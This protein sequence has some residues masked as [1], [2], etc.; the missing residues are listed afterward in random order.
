MLLLIENNKMVSFCWGSFGIS[1]KAE[2]ESSK[3][4]FLVHERAV[5]WEPHVPCDVIHCLLLL[6]QNTD[7][8]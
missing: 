1:M 7:A 3:S 8:F 6:I 2:R 5:N 4:L